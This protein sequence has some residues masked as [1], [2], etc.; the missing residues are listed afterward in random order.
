MEKT[1]RLLQ[2]LFAM[3]LVIVFRVWHLGVIQREEKKI[4]A[5]KPQQRQILLR[6]NRGT[7][8]DRFGIPLAVNRICYN[9]SIYYGQIA[10][11]PV[12]S[13]QGDEKGGR[14]K[15]YSRREYIHKLAAVLASLLQLDAERVED[16]IHAKAS[17]FPYVPYLLKA[18]LTEEEYY[19]LKMLEKDWLGI[20]AEIGAERYYPL[21]KSAAHI[22]GTMGPINQKEY[23]AIADEMR[24]L[25]ESL[26][27]MDLSSPEDLET[28]KARE[29]LLE[30]KEK[31]YTL[32]DLIGKSGVEAEWEEEL[33]GQFGKTTF[34]VDQKGR[35]VRELPEAK[36]PIAGRPIRLTI[37]I[38]LQ[39]Y[40]EQLLAQVEKAR[41]KRPPKQP[42]IRGGA[43]VVLDPNTGEILSMA[44]HPSF[45]PND[46]IPSAN[47][48]LRKEKQRKINLWLE[49]ESWIGA[50]WEGREALCGGKYD[51]QCLSW[52][53][54]LDLILPDGEHPL[55]SFFQKVCDIK[56][57][58]QVQ[59]DFAALRYFGGGKD[60]F[61]A[62]APQAALPKKRLSVLL[63]E[64]PDMRDRLFAIDICKLAIDA[65]RISD[66]L[67]S[68]IGN[69]KLSAFFSLSQLFHQYEQREKQKGKETF[70]HQAF[71]AWKE[72]HQKAFLA[73]KR[74]EE[75]ESNTY[76]RPYLD[77]LDAKEK[78]LFEE[79][80]KEQRLRYLTENLE[81]APSLQV[82]SQDLQEDFLHTF[83]PFSQFAE[84]EKELAM[85]FYP[86]GGLG[87]SRSYAFQASAPQGSLFK[88][89]T[90]YE[91]L[92]QG[93]ALSLIDEQ[94]QSEKGLIVAYDLKKN[95][96]PRFYKG[97]RLPKSSIPHIGPIDIVGA[98]EQ[99]SNP[100][101]SIVA[102]DYL[103]S[104][105][106]LCEAARLFGYGSPT[107]I[108]LAGEAVGCLPTDLSYN[109]TGLYSFAIGQH[110]LLATPLQSA[111]V[112]STLANGGKL[113][114]P[115]IIRDSADVTIRH[116]LAFPLSIRNQ[117][118]E[119]LDRCLWSAKGKAR[120]TAIRSLL[121]NPSLMRDYLT[122]QHQ[123]IAKTGT[124]EVLWKA[125]RNPGSKAS[126]HK[127]VW[128]GA[129]SFSQDAFATKQQRWDHPELV[130]VVMQRFGD[131]GKDLA[132]IAAQMI[133]KWRSIQ[134]QHRK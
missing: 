9:A 91:G 49:T 70:H 52:D 37:S 98:L 30:L 113:L 129:I 108:E 127:H 7:I 125:Y 19:K 71:R 81:T 106:D 128:F 119:G 99:S 117:I 33:R 75:K 35:F 126:L 22:L 25:K 115:K 53:L 84:K 92:K 109:R 20:H 74:K 102:G 4:E 8:S 86:Q 82:V 42:W 116:T 10:Q 85:T 14:I 61:L 51:G 88:V 80:W 38:E 132:P 72:T 29:R 110:T 104:P 120:P 93:V 36:P 63:A 41:A 79:S 100:F 134:E 32:N 77:Y 76:A 133:C 46:F 13:W 95:P 114:K 121:S 16:L 47:L 122:L 5:Q 112:V 18:H 28:E 57:A 130:V 68:K 96:Y 90:A 45:D 62:E 87:F 67:L 27:F 83:R 6:A 31:A 89:V 59:E 23:L 48:E 1:Q 24:R 21:G 55:R 123:M 105:E 64:I 97:G 107:G 73:E 11:I 56:T 66:R 39:H 69:M 54:F 103:K 2:I 3:F 15:V 50:L 118:F 43:I 78:E 131:A 12:V 60:P 124:A 58:V 94:S 40:A 34:E 111:L 26:E 44:S 65:T 17:L 101:F